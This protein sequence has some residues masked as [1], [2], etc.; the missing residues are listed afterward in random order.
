MSESELAEFSGTDRFLIRR[1]V[2]A[3]GMG[4]VYEAYDRAHE[5]RVALKTLL[6][7]A[8]AGL[9]R[10]KQEFRNLAGVVHPNLATLY[11]LFAV[12]E[13]WFFTMEFVEGCDFLDYIRHGTAGDAAGRAAEIS[14]FD[15]KTLQLP[16]RGLPI[17][18]VSGVPLTT[19]EQEQ[20]LRSSLLQLAQAISAL[21]ASNSLHCDIKPSN[22]LVTAEGRTVLLD[23][24]LSTALQERDRDSGR[25]TGTV[26]YMSPEQA[27]GKSLTAA[28]DWYAVGAMLFE[29]LTGR[30]TFSGD[31]AH[32]LAMKQQQDAPDLA[33]LSPD[34][35]ADL[36]ALCRDLLRRDPARRPTGPEIIAR[37]GGSSSL[38]VP[39]VERIPLVGRDRE[40]DALREALEAARS[41]RATAV[42]VHGPSGEGKSFL[43]SRFLE[44]I[45]DDPQTAI[46]NGRCY[47]TE[48]VPYK[49]LDSLIDSLSRYLRRRDDLAAEILPRDARL[50]TRV[51]PTLR[52]VKAMESAPERRTDAP[53]DQELR[54]RTSAALRELLGRLGDRMTLVLCI[55]DLQWGD[56]DSGLMLSELLRAPDP[57]LLLF[58]GLYR[59]EYVSTSPILK[60]ILAA[61]GE[62]GGSDR[63]QVS[64][65]ALTHEEARKLAGELLGN[66]DDDP[67]ELADKL[68]SES[69]GVPYFVH[70]LANYI[71]A[72]ARLDADESL[73]LEQVLARRFD[74]LADAP[75]RVLQTIAV[76]GQPIRQR[77]VYAAAGVEGEERAAVSLLRSGHLVRGTGTGEED[78]LETYH[79]RVRET[80]VARLSTTEAQHHHAR[81]ADVLEQSGEAD[82][83]TLAGH[84]HG[85]GASEK[86]ASYYADAAARAASAFAFDRAATLYRQSLALRNA[87]DPQIHELRVH[88]GDALANAGRGPEAAREY[89][90]A[91]LD[92][93]P[94]ETAELQRR[95]AY[96]YCASGYVEE[97][98]A[99][100]KELL[101]QNGVRLPS[102]GNGTLYTLLRNRARLWWRGYKFQETKEA[103]VAPSTLRR[104]DIL[105]SASAGLS[106]IDILGSAAIQTEGLLAA[107]DAGEIY[108]AAR[109]L[110]WEAAHT[111]NMGSKASKKTAELLARAR[112]LAD[113]SGHPHALAMYDL[114]SGLAEYTSGRWG[115]SVP[116]LAGS[117]NMFRER[118]TGVAWE[119]NTA[120]AF[121]LWALIYSGEFAEMAIA[122]ETAL[123]DAEARGDLYTYTNLA[124]YMKPHAL[125]AADD[126]AGARE[127]VR[128]SRSRWSQNGFYLQNL[129]DVWS[130]TQIDLY[131][132]N[133]WSA[134]KRLETSWPAIKKS[135]MLTIQLLYILLHH[136]RG[137]AALTAAA[138]TGRKGVPREALLRQAERY[139]KGIEGQKIDWGNG[140]AVL[141]RAGIASVRG[142]R[143]QAIDLLGR[144]AAILDQCTMGSY[145]AS[146][147]RYQGLLIGGTEGAALVSEADAWLSQRGVRDPARM[148]RMHVGGITAE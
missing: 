80:V 38:A 56:L 124:S 30:V 17:A 100:M 140:K 123:K 31:T 143:N 120:A 26:S 67:S 109:S 59:S 86:A 55:D 21:H 98:R 8:S 62:Q 99:A 65:G 61:A 128:D 138:E 94:D 14:A 39:A 1:R 110:A 97:G 89:T 135:L 69:G 54:R 84:F 18:A 103:E 129:T 71:R 78:F 72:G 49:A 141:L 90:A 119:I 117:E 57:P 58:I 125:L 70:E 127:S 40:M 22:V 87:S 13:T 147:R 108:R 142:D 16:R 25:I 6:L 34:I 101:R 2:G 43:L 92:A 4:V 93:T 104:I 130:E 7:G 88:L 28:S 46:L 133:G 45:Q 107:L 53:S 105:W 114:A 51:F 68:A 20:R 106:L 82:A 42:F 48:S 116:L 3:G 137:R 77:H 33:S 63:R 81:L 139:A 37:L 132:G 50:L 35:P 60:T 52:E 118:C 95:A 15:E 148:A 136:L 85:A 115:K 79:D 145:G 66:A 47:E 102:S 74:L 41:G 134:W 113:R 9:Y 131:E 29:A 144:S 24:G 112:E 75:R 76:A 121:R 5:M 27:A 32:V 44:Q 146:A 19:P 111:S 36:D 96:Q 64:I 10:F 12:D 126:P 73:S 11:E 23:F 122:T 83:E 91:V